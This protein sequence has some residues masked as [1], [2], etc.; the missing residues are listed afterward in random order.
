MYYP[1]RNIIVIA[2]VLFMAQVKAFG[3]W[4]TTAIDRLKQGPD[5]FKKIIESERAYE[6]RTFNGRGT[7]YWPIFSKINKIWHYEQ[8]L[9]FGAGSFQKISDVYPDAMLWSSENPTWNDII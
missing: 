1:F 9:L 4:C 3:E 8:E 5:D 6:D 2:I 7:L